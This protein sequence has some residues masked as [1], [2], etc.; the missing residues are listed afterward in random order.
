MVD[1]STIAQRH[2]KSTPRLSVHPSL[3][4]PHLQLVSSF[5]VS[6]PQTRLPLK[7]ASSSAVVVV[8]FEPTSRTYL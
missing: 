2:T 7:P 4:L 6:E 8:E 1:Y 3:P 5:F